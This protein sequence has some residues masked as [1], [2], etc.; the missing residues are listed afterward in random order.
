[1]LT[2]LDRSKGHQKSLD[3]IH[4]VYATKYSPRGDRILVAGRDAVARVWD[5]TW[6]GGGRSTGKLLLKLAG[7]TEAIT[8]CGWRC[9]GQRAVTASNDKTA[10]VW[11]AKTGEVFATLL[12]HGGHVR[13]CC[14][15]RDG[16]VFTGSRDRTV[17]VW[18][19]KWDVGSF[20]ARTLLGHADRVMAVAAS[21]DDKLLVSASFD[22]TVRCWDPD[23]PEDVF[24]DPK[25]AASTITPQ[26]SVLIPLAEEEEDSWLD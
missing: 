3:E 8:A 4:Y 11:N 12:G 15:L 21:P 9:D 19:D 23:P 16:R 7:H 26:G 1:M 24:V 17:R 18:E 6:D 13:A 2:L 10:K 20:V 25:F 22:R 14:F 5:A